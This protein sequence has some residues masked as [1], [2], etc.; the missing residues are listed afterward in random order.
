MPQL[1][2]LLRDPKIFSSLESIAAAR[3]V[4]RFLAMVS[5]KCK[6]H[7]RGEGNHGRRGGGCDRLGGLEPG[8]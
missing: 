2:R 4:V 6:E 3:A 8:I 1:R 5:R 7:E